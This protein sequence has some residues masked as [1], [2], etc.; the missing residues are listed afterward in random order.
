MLCKNFTSCCKNFKST[1]VEESKFEESVYEVS[2][3]T[4]SV[5]LRNIPISIWSQLTESRCGMCFMC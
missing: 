4:L 3:K 2:V 5:I 1:H